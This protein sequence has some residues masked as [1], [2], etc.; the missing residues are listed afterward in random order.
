MCP[1]LEKKSSLSKEE[2]NFALGYYKKK[3]FI[4]IMPGEK[5]RIQLTEVAKATQHENTL[6]LLEKIS[7]KQKISEEKILE[8]IMDSTH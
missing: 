3:N 4:V 5:P 7:E 1:H 8:L 6:A 2:F